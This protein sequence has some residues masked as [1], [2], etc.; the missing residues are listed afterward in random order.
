MRRAFQTCR[1][2]PKNGLGSP[3]IGMRRPIAQGLN[4]YFQRFEPGLQRQRLGLIVW[5]DGREAEKT[6]T[7]RDGHRRR[8]ASGEPQKSW[9]FRRQAEPSCGSM[10][11]RCPQAARSPPSAVPSHRYPLAA[12]TAHKARRPTFCTRRFFHS[13]GALP[14]TRQHKRLGCTHHPSRRNDSNPLFFLVIFRFTAL[15][16]GD[17]I[18]PADP[19]PQKNCG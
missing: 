12:V 18:G 17:V 15:P 9:G 10:D 8:P 1:C 19:G 16:T 13:T 3:G 6:S 2:D 14:P 5:S 11:A 7:A 4:G